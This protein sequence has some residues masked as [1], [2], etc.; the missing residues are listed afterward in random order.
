MTKKASKHIPNHEVRI[1]A[2]KKHRL[3]R[4]VQKTQQGD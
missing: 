3:D 2:V 1:V 4:E